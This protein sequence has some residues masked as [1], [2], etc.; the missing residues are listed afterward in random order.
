MKL[1]I[2]RL[3]WEQEAVWWGLCHL[4]LHADLGLSAVINPKWAAN[5]LRFKPRPRFGPQ[6]ACCPLG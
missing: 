2:L 4:N 5:E 3:P 1:L 6:Q